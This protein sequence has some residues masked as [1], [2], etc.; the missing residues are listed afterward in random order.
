MKI[1]QGFV[2]NSSSSSFIVKFPRV[3]NSVDDVREML[4]GNTPFFGNPYSDDLY[5]V[6]KVA[7]TVFNDIQNQEA[8]KIEEAITLLSNSWECP[9]TY[10]DYKKDPNDWKTMD[11]DAYNRDCMEWAKSE[12]ENFYSLKKIRKDKINKIEGKEESNYD[13]LYIFEY[14]DNDGSYGATLEHGG[15]F[16]NLEHIVISNH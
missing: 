11:H 13:L 6:E 15:L 9:I 7:K 10:D 1:R 8:N 12:F 3:P 2:S 16:D 5:P 4:F 14:S